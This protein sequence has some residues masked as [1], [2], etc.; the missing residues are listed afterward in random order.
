MNPREI[1]SI[2]LGVLSVV[3]GL[4]GVWFGLRERGERL[5]LEAKLR[6]QAWSTLD[7][8]R[9]VIGDH[10]LFKEFD[11]QLNHPEKYHLWNIHQAASDL[12]ISLVEQY[13]SQVEQFTYDDL[14]KLCDN[15]FIYWRWQ[16]KQWRYHI[17]QRPENIQRDVPDFF[18]KEDSR[19]FQEDANRGVVAAPPAKDRA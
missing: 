12:Y 3:T 8:A 15:R 2:C 18:T 19:P 17:C 1:V 10:I 11:Q 13:L 9:Y 6:S 16:E 4:W 7:R 14:K 5:K